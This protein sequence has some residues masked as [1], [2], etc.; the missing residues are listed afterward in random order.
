M[1]TKNKAPVQKGG[2]F[3]LPSP[4]CHAEPRQLPR[5][6]IPCW[7]QGSQECHVLTA[8]AKSQETFTSHTLRGSNFR[9]ATR[10]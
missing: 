4:S 3:F 9:K 6:C 8:K 7:S 10:T 5:K 1:R 2:L